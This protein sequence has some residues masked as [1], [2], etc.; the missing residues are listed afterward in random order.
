MPEQDYYSIN[1]ILAIIHNYHVKINIIENLEKGMEL[2]SVGVSQYGDDAGM[3]K[4]NNNSSATENEA[5]RIA[6]SSKL[7]SNAMTD[8]KYIQQRWH[9]VTDEQQAI[10]LHLRL[11]GYS[12]T[13][14]SHIIKKKKSQTYNLLR[15]A[16]KAIKGYPQE[17]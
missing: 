16:A 14:I 17:K 5:L 10:A 2:K 12:I 7:W 6:R 8:I 15:G 4:A 9:R 1:K 3:P 13:D 11:S